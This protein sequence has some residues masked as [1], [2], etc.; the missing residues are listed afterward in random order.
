MS[1]GKT[2]PSINLSWLLAQSQGVRCLLIDADLRNPCIANY[3]GFAGERGLSEILSGEATFEESLVQ[4]Q[5]SG[6]YFLPGGAARSDV[7]E[8]LSGP[9]FKD[10]LVRTRDMF[11]YV[12]ID[13]PPLGIFTDA[14]LLINRADA[15]MLVVR[16]FHTRT[17]DVV[18]LL[19][20]LPRERMLGIVLNQADEELP[21]SYY[22]YYRRQRT[23]SDTPAASED[24]L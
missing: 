3:L 15:A 19:E 17:K 9:T 8:M 12:I 7:A 22:Y 6:L 24:E 21:E 11:D 14:S 16:A 20:Q 5:P 2:L 1:E 23:V 13:A 10:L 4:L 18:R